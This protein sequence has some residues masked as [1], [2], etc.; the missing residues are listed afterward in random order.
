MKPPDLSL[1]RD[2]VVIPALVAI[3]SYSKAAERLV[4][5]TGLAESGFVHV[6]QVAKYK[7]GGGIAKYGPARGY[8][9][10]EP[11]THDD[12]W[13]NYLGAT[14][15]APLLAGLRSLSDCPGDVD[16][17]IRNPQ[18][19]AA[20]CRIFYLRV[21]APLPAPHDLRGMAEYWKRYYNTRLG[22]G[23][24]EGFMQKAAEVM[25]L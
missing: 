25:T 21:P 6:R 9:Q 13:A 15:R 11:F 18:Y 14:K 17:L 10:M 2:R 4:M 19:A 1:I 8:F 20:M 24:V 16:E 7:P 23:T 22:K 3:D 12:I 5:A